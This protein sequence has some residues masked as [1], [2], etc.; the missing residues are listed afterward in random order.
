M[1]ENP[2]RFDIAHLARVELFSPK[3]QETEEFFTKFLGLRVTKREG[4]SVYLRAFEDPYQWSLKVTEAPEAGMGHAALR[5]QSAEALE[6]RVSSLKDANV[7]G[8]L[9]EDDFGY[10]KTFSYQ[11]P[12][13]HNLSLL[14][15]AEKYVAPPELQSKILTRPSKKPL[16]GIPVKRIDHLNLMASDVSA[17]RNSFERHLGFR[18]TES[19]VDGD[20]EIGAWMSSN[21]LGHEVACMKD[22][23]G[24]RGKLHHV[25]FFYGN[26][27]HNIDAA[28]MFR[29]YDIQIEAGPDV[30]GITQG[31]FLYVFEPGGN[32]I[33]L[34][35]EAGYLHMDPDAETKTWQ[36]S[37]IDTGLAIGGA[38]LPWETYFTYGTPCVLNLD[39]HIEAF[40]HFGPGEPLPEAHLAA[41]NMP[42]EIEQSRAV[43]GAPA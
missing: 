42:D 5:T 16:Q 32:R 36:M 37:D 33:E 15:E 39:R 17:I 21:L 7:E 29:D 9:H 27:Q 14:W 35:G 10:G 23:T 41:A 20:T 22:M 38:K 25:A 8:K 28:E 30:H 1:A 13:G 34:F 19:V 18:T 12:D 2:A 4:Q 40:A 11:S 6:R 26:G 24:G 3:P 31:Q 43:A